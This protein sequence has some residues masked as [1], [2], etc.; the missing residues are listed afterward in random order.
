MAL[1]F[2]IVEIKSRDNLAYFND[3]SHTFFCG[4]MDLEDFACSF[5]L[6]STMSAA[7]VKRVGG[8]VRL[9]LPPSGCD[10][11]A[12]QLFVPSISSD[13]SLLDC[14]VSLF[15]FVDRPRVQGD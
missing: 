4:E 11:V 6:S 15:T 7:G 9:L 13:G 14:V 1:S 2:N 3:A 12:W 8:L 5:T 10:F